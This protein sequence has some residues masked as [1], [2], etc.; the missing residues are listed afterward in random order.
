[1]HERVIA[2]TRQ[3]G[4]EYVV[5]N[6]AWELDLEASGARIITVLGDRYA[7]VRAFQTGLA[8]IRQAAASK[9]ATLSQRDT[10][11]SSYS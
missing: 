5:A 9:Q 11:G 8:G 7:L 3:A 1:M 10:N 6:A 4:I 2:A